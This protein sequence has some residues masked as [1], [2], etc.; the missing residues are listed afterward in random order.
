[1]VVGVGTCPFKRIW[2]GYATCAKRRQYLG[3][4]HD[5]RLRLAAEPMVGSR[6][7]RVGC[8]AHLTAWS[9]RSSTSTAESLVYECIRRRRC[10][11]R[12]SCGASSAAATLASCWHL[13]RTLQRSRSTPRWAFPVRST[14][15][16]R[17]A[18]GGWGASE[19]TNWRS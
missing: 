8:D 14:A 9:P 12:R 1:M 2:T 19:S 16:V 4:P 13:S 7:K 18:I 3:T 17:G 15:R 11:K 10:F 5:N 6:R